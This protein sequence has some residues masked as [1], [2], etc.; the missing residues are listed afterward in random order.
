MHLGEESMLPLSINAELHKNQ[1][2]T[3]DLRNNRLSKLF[4]T[5]NYSSVSLMAL[6]AQEILATYLWQRIGLFGLGSCNV[7]CEPT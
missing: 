3:S 5:D 6:Q 4:F 7:V 1:A 2:T